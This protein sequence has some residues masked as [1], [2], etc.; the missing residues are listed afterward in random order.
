MSMNNEQCYMKSILE[1]P[2][3]IEIEEYREYKE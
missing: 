2:R 3:D 1:A